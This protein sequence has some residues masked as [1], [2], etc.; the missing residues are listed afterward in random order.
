[1]FSPQPAARLSGLGL[2]LMMFFSIGATAQAQGLVKGMQEGAEAG[3]KAAGPVG[4]VL[5]GAIGAI[6][7]VF[8][9]ALGVGN[10]KPQGQ[11]QQQQP[12]ANAAT[13]TNSPAKAAAKSKAVK[14]AKASPMP[15]PATTASAKP[16]WSRISIVEGWTVSP[17]NSRSKSL[18]ISRSVTGTPRRARRRESMTPAGPPPTMQQEVCVT[19]T[20]G[21][22]EISG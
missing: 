19:P 13:N 4:G 16:I 3:N 21:H 11:P 10:E 6:G 14:T 22:E 20:T 7:G 5:G 2:A 18:C 17:R 15:V 8:G 9:G 1:M 12:T